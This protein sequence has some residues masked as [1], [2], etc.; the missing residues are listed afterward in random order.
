M[1]AFLPPSS[2]VANVRFS[3]ALRRTRRPVSVAPVKVIR[4]TRGWLE[5]AGP[6]LRPGTALITPGG[7]TSLA[8][9]TRRSTV[10]GACSPGLTM[11][12]FPAASAGA[13][14]LVK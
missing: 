2:I 1:T 7:S 9:S 14:F 8:S 6:A 13:H 12:V 5:S 11:T 10:S 4:S 3:A